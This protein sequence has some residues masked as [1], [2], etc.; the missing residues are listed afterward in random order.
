[1][2]GGGT[3]LMRWEYL[4]YRGRWHLSY[5]GSTYLIRGEYLSYGVG[6]HLSYG[7]GW[8]LSYGVRLGSM[9]VS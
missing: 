2:G 7:V 4:S 5:E 3:Y 6:W 9:S 8:L 1:M